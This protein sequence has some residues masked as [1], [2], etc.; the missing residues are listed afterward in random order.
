MDFNI[1]LF[2]N[3][4]RWFPKIR[5]LIGTFFFKISGGFCVNIRT[6]EIIEQSLPFYKISHFIVSFQPFLCRLALVLLKY[7]NGVVPFMDSPFIA[8]DFLH[9]TI[10]ICGLELLH[11][12]R[13]PEMF[14]RSP[15]VELAFLA[16]V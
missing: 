6:F 14:L 4:F 1:F 12:F 11:L 10:S 7:R 16:E 8:D 9:V 13:L 2:I 5:F 3:P 15:L